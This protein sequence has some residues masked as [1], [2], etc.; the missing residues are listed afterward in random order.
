MFKKGASPEVLT[1]LEKSLKKQEE[2][3]NYYTKNFLPALEVEITNSKKLD[4]KKQAAIVQTILDIT[5]RSSNKYSK[6]E[7]QPIN[8]IKEE[9]PVSSTGMT[10]NNVESLM[11][12]DQTQQKLESL[13]PNL[14]NK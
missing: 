8:S 7:E 13:I 3:Y 4:S 14:I 2:S 12:Q 11:T 9:I 1:K 10:E 5:N 6:I